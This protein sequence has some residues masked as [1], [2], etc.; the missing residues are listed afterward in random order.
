MKDRQTVDS[1]LRELRKQESILVSKG[2]EINKEA[3][4]D[5]CMKIEA[6]IWVLES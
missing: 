5:L 3:I 2:A 6:L 1:R 4:R